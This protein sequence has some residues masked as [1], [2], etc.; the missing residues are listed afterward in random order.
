M[1][2]EARIANPQQMFVIRLPLHGIFCQGMFSIFQGQRV[3]KDVDQR[4]FASQPTFTIEQ[5]IPKAGVTRFG[6]P[7]RLANGR[8]GAIHVVWFIVLPSDPT[9][10]FR[11][12]M[13]AIFSFFVRQVL[14]KVVI[15]DPLLMCGN[16]VFP[17]LRCFEIPVSHTS[18]HINYV[19]YSRRSPK[20]L[21]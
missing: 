18:L 9:K 14:L 8:K 2:I 12:R 1:I 17:A 5:E 7:P 10:Y 20:T 15:Q 11:W 3:L 16:K 19:E 13:T 21:Q 6:K 4:L